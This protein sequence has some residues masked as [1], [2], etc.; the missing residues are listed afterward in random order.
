M[1]SNSITSCQGPLSLVKSFNMRNCHT[2][3]A[4]NY[5]IHLTGTQC[6]LVVHRNHLKLCH[7]NHRGATPVLLSGFW[8]S[9]ADMKN[10]FCTVSSSTGSTSSGEKPTHLPQ[11]QQACCP[12]KRYGNQS[13]PN[14]EYLLKITQCPYVVD[15]IAVGLLLLK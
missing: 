3:S 1:I 2:H 13:P 6:Q 10:T 11:Q 5:C 7:G 9:Y 12:P 4:V 14:V 8:P 15:V